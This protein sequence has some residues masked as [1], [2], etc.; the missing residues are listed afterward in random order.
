MTSQVEFEAYSHSAGPTYIGFRP[1]PPAPLVPFF[2]TQGLRLSI[3]QASFSFASVQFSFG[4]P[5]NDFWIFHIRFV[6]MSSLNIGLLDPFRRRGSFYWDQGLA[7]DFRSASARG[8]AE[9][10][11]VNRSGQ[12]IVYRFPGGTRTAIRGPTLNRGVLTQEGSFN[13]Y[14][15][16]SSL[17]SFDR[18]PNTTWKIKLV[19]SLANPTIQEDPPSFGTSTIPSKVWQNEVTITPFT[20]PAAT[21]GQ[22]GRLSYSITGLARGVQMNQDRLIFGAP[23]VLSDTVRTALSLIHI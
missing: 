17:P 21:D 1:F 20:V 3:T 10:S 9:L 11:Y 13:F 6:P 12:T 19:S 16:A 4:G 5:I 22:E 15:P 23:T 14:V 18:A 2:W 7:S 8:Y